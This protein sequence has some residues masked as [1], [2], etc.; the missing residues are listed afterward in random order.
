[1]PGPAKLPLVG[2]TAS[3]L[4]AWSAKELKRTSRARRARAR[5]QA[6]RPADEAKPSLAEDDVIVRWTTADER[7][8]R[9]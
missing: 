9:R 5:R 8:S 2:I 1:M 4:T 7:R 3:N 6:R